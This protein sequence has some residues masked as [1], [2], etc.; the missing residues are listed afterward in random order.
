MEPGALRVCSILGAVERQM[1]AGAKP[2]PAG[3]ERVN[4][5]V[6]FFS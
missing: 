6:A 1:W 3:M 5:T 2:A 4:L